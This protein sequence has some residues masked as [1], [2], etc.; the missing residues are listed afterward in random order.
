[1]GPGVAP[2]LSAIALVKNPIIKN[3][4]KHI[5]I[6]YHFIR[7]KYNSG[8]LDVSY[9]PSGDNVADI[10]TKQCSKGEE[11]EEI[12]QKNIFRHA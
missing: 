2:P 6:K 7:E 1:M 12:L 4:S 8:F 11:L 9:I 5:D 10:M 3:R